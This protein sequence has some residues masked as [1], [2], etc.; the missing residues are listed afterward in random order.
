MSDDMLDMEYDGDDFDEQSME[1]DDGNVS[2][3]VEEVVEEEEDNDP[4]SWA[5][6]LD[7]NK[8][9]KTWTQYT[10]TREEHQG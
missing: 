2:D 7:P 9:Q 4:W 5:A 3:D 10:Q 8:V 6:D 1:E